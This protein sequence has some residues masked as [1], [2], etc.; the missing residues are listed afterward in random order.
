MH[1]D[2]CPYLDV[3]SMC[4]DGKQTNNPDMG[5]EYGVS[6]RCFSNTTLGTSGGFVDLAQNTR[7]LKTSC[8]VATG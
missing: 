2:Y 6:S 1:T 3:L 8:N 5:V 7:C 4:L